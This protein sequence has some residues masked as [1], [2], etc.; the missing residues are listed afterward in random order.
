M[1]VPKMEASARR[2]HILDTALKVFSAKGYH[3]TR[4]REL[5]K[6]AGISEPLIYKYFKGK[7]DLYFCL[8]KELRLTMLTSWENAEKSFEKPED[9]LR[10]F[11]MEYYSVVI[12]SPD[13]ARVL[14]QTFAEAGMEE[15]LQFC[16]DLQLTLHGKIRKIIEDG[17]R[18]GTFS[19]NVDVGLAAW[20]FLSIGMTISV[21]SALGLQE[22]FGPEKVITWGD[23][24]IEGLKRK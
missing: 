14:F 3:L 24:F 8:L 9:I 7:E 2:Q 21:M 23:I 1:R 16:R 17:V 4:T 10:A 18:E 12:Q 19:E 15:V 6:E 13:T 20:R 5:A 22:Q 11:G